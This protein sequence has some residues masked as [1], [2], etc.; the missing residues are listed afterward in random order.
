MYKCMPWELNCKCCG[1]LFIGDRCTREFCSG[2][3]RS[4]W[5]QDNG[6]GYKPRN[7]ERC[8]A[9]FQPIH[10]KRRYCYDCTES[11]RLFRRGVTS[12][13]YAAKMLAQ[14]EQCAICRIAPAVAI[15]HN[16]KTGA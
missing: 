1:Q 10:G 14:G 15:D 12:D 13:E 8:G 3:C 7:C 4:Q 9:E 16:H 11:R 6:W 2:S 5:R